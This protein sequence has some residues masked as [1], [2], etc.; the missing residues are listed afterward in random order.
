MKKSLLALGLA[1]S[2]VFA[3]TVVSSTLFEDQFDS[4]DYSNYQSDNFILTSANLS[5][6]MAFDVMHAQQGP[7]NLNIPGLDISE[8][9]SIKTEFVLISSLIHNNN[10]Y[11]SFYNEMISWNNFSMET[12]IHEPVIISTEFNMTHNDVKSF[13]SDTAVANTLI[14]PSSGA[15]TIMNVVNSNS[16]VT[17]NSIAGG[18][19]S[20]GAT[21]EE[22][23]SLYC[24][25]T[26]PDPS[27]MQTCFAGFFPLARDYLTL[28]INYIKVTGYKTETT[29]ALN[30]SIA[31]DAVLIGSF[32]ILGQEVNANA[33]GI[34]I[35]KYSDG[36]T[37]RVYRN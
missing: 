35:E 28:E 3:Q 5:T 21:T 17:I 31:E 15:L 12:S 23:V 24:T 11:A 36:S 14:T 10:A 20:Q 8:Y 32:D 22:A 18:T 37:L 9:D 29:T 25:E 13:I 4:G 19:G 2:A 34:V 6:A 33:S 16:L 1:S 30:E 7:I 26:Y 27:E